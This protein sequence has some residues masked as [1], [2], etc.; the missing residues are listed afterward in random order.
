MTL[1]KSLYLS[2]QPQGGNNSSMYLIALLERLSK[3]IY[4]QSSFFFLH[5]VLKIV[6][7]LLRKH[8]VNI[9]YFIPILILFTF[10][11]LIFKK[12]VFFWYSH[13]K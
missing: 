11:K 10:F 7:L 2:F 12:L 4:T 6:I 13:L 8:S 5:E 9:R 1:N 3:I